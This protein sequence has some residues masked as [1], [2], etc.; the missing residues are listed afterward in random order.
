MKKIVFNLLLVFLILFTS[1]LY[2]KYEWKIAKDKNGYEYKYVQGDHLNCRIYILQNGLTVF[3]RQLKDEPRIQTYIAVRAGSTYDP[4]ETTGLAHYLEHMMFKGTSKIGSANWEKEKPLLDEISRLF[5]LHKATNDPQE[6]KRI[7]RI[8]DSLSQIAATYAIPSEYDKMV[9]GIGAK[10][11]NAYTSTERTVYVNNIPSNE[12]ERWLIIESERFSELVLR[13]FHTELETVYEEFNMYQD[14]DWSRVDEVFNAAMFPKHPYGTQTVIGKPEHLKNPSMV[15]I[16]NYFNNFYVPNNMAISLSGDLDFEETIKLIDKYFGKLKKGNPPQI[17]HPKEDPITKPI[18]KEVYGPQAEFLVLGYRLPGYNDPDIIKA[19]LLDKILYNGKAGLIDLNLIKSQ[20]V[21]EASSYLDRN[22]DYSIHSFNATPREGQTL[23]EVKNLILEQI[24]KIKKGEFDDW[25]I[26][27][28]INNLKLSIIRNE[29]TNM[30]AHTFV[31]SFTMKEDWLNYYTFIDKLQKITKND[32]IKF[33]NEYYKDNY[34][35]VYKRLGKDTNIV[36]VEKPEI[37]PVQMNRDAQSEFFKKIMSMKTPPLEPVFLDFEK[38]I[39]RL[40]LKNGI[41]FNYIVNSIN[42]YFQLSFILD[43]GKDHDLKTELAV[44]YLP[45]IGTNKYTPEDLSKEFYKLGIN[46]SVS[47]YDYRTYIT[48]SG[49][50]QN[51]QKGIELLEHTLANAKPDEKIYK[52]FVDGII[53]SR[54]D[55]KLDKN[56]I[57]WQAMYYYGMYDGKSPFTNILSENELRSINPKELTDI[58]K[59]LL[60]YKHYIFYYGKDANQVKQI[61]EKIHKVDAKKLKDYPK[62]LKYKER[63]F[64][65]NMVLIVDYDMVQANVLFMSKDCKFDK[66]LIPYARIFN[67]YF[68][69]GLSSIVFQEIREARALA[70]SAFSAY[71]TPAKSDFSNFVFGFVGTQ[72]D[73]LKIATDALVSL[74]NDMPKATAQ[75]DQS[76]EGVMRKIESERITKASIFWSY[77]SNKDR[78]IN[79]DIRKDIYEKMKNISLEELDEFFKKHISNKKYIFLILANKKSLD[80]D[81]LKQIGEIKELTLEE[82]FNY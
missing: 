12:L 71:S 23:E 15:N 54:N 38:D 2:A 46:L 45:Y 47:T 10:G 82:I 20:K 78:G 60:S 24:E 32:L 68:G 51:L 66:N 77:L 67:E 25:L 57:L 65:K 27:A 19:Y 61:I 64:T 28:V 26:E 56:T 17:E 37:T 40:T 69:G 44:N 63:D 29:E 42:D 75:F 6:K 50:K 22:I 62:P 9:T 16:H 79:Y 39:K 14:E 3:L 8:I 49:L 41:E 73:K 53:K 74:L 11:T 1:N 81:I 13:L 55:A 59:N 76:R 33:A 18:I 72:P 43:M 5:E 31:I 7:Y 30:I 35:C 52:D 58:L 4:K 48:I 21:L 34:V 70:Y 36:K 80:Y